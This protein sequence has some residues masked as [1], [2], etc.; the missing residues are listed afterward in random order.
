M[1]PT[2][3]T[4]PIL[5]GVRHADVKELNWTLKKGLG[6]TAGNSEYIIPLPPLGRGMRDVIYPP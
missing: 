6:N 2:D 4:H 3:K 5:R 1:S